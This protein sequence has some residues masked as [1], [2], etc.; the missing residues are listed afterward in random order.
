MK[1]TKIKKENTE[2]FHG[3]E[4]AN[5]AIL[6][7]VYKAKY[8]IDACL[9]SNSSDFLGSNNKACRCYKNRPFDRKY[10]LDCNRIMRSKPRGI[11][12]KNMIVSRAFFR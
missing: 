8:R 2:I 6:N 12:S 11:S 9:D 3:I 5:N 7:F 4:D 10:G 1:G